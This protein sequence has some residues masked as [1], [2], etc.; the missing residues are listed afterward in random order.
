LP[1][2][3]GERKGQAHALLARAAD[4]H[5]AGITTGMK[6]ISGGW[7]VRKHLFLNATWLEATQPLSRDERELLVDLVLQA[8]LWESRTLPLTVEAIEGM[9]HSEAAR[10]AMIGLF[11]EL[12]RL[13]L[14]RE[15]APGQFEIAPGLWRLEE[16]ER[17]GSGRTIR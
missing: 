2:G 6:P 3:P 13:D 1:P 5:G 14:V 9:A 16:R 12:C 4:C 15:I 17:E 8:A 7:M 11:A 10:P